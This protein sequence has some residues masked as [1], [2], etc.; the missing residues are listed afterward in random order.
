MAAHDLKNLASRLAALSQN[1]D[2]NF[3]DPLF[4]PTALDILKD[5]V[6]HLQRL[7]SDIRDHEGRLTVKLRVDVSRLLEE[8][9]MDVRPGLGS[10]CEI[11]LDARELP[12]I[13]GDAFLLRRAFACAIE[14]SLEAMNGAGGTLA[15]STRMR[16]RNGRSRI[17]V[18]ICDDGPGMDPE[19]IRKRL[20]CPFGST[21]ENGMGLGVYTMNQIAS[22][23]GGRVRIVSDPGSGT[24]VRFFFPAGG[25]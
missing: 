7:A 23:H 14:N 1:L 13:W 11:L 4:K 17:V 19:F 6:G 15:L 9:L 16:R 3:D 22:L 25:A 21:K 24:R 10:R 20:F 5:T 2:D 18:E 12:L 8:A